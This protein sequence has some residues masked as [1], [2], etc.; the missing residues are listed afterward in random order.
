[1][2]RELK[3]GLLTL[4][5][6]GLSLWGYQYIK[7][8]NILN[9]VKSYSAVYNNVE[10]LAVAGNVEING[11]AIGSIQKIELNNDDVNTMIVS[12]EVEGDYQ[13][14]KN[15]VAALSTSNS[16]VGSKKIVLHFDKLCESDCLESGDRMISG[17]RGVLESILPKSDL[18]GHLG[19]LREEIGGIMD[20]VINVFNGR[21]ADNTVARSLRD[22]EEAMK[23]LASLTAT[24][25]KF[26]KA[27]YIDLET[28]IANMA[29][30]TESL[31]RGSGEI[32]QIMNNVSEI[33]SQLANADIGKTI[34]RTDETFDKTN[35]LLTDLQASVKEVNS[36][37]DKMNGILSQVEKGEGT[38]GQFLENED[39]YKNMNLLL[40]DLRLNPK[41]Y[42]RFSVFGR[43][44]KDYTYPDGDPAFDPNVLKKEKDTPPNQ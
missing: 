23:N 33:T 17:T 30:I 32:K 13:F 38:I 25:D 43:K 8:K 19:V 11:M 42:I 14:P 7:G 9:K 31:Q 5:I 44:G 35:D 16:L 18:Q 26:T 21:D 27:T 22:M 1:M 34:K 39:M 3:L 36:S 29:D 4:I 15:T 2:S 10:G 28:T 41:R 20:S 12:F 37:F 6:T 40:Q 24:M